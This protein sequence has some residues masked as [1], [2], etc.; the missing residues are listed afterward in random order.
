MGVGSLRP[1]PDTPGV[2]TLADAHVD[3]NAATGFER[4]LYPLKMTPGWEGASGP[5]PIRWLKVETVASAPGKAWAWIRKE[6][7]MSHT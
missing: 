3:P 5:W 6:P 2:E 1:P 4:P 7:K